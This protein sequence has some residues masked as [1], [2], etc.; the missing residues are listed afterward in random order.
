VI[1]GNR[2]GLRSAA[3]DGGWTSHGRTEP[4]AAAAAATAA[5]HGGGRWRLYARQLIGPTDGRLCYFC[6]RLMTMSNITFVSP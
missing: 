2:N 3:S 5:L 6:V 1:H 4:A